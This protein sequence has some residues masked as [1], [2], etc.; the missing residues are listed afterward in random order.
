[1]QRSSPRHHWRALGGIGLPIAPQKDHLMAKLL[2][3]I[4]VLAGMGA[5]TLASAALAAD[6]P[7]RVA[8]P[9]YSPPPL[10]AFTWTGFYIGV[11]AGGIFPDK[12]D[13]AFTGDPLVVGPAIAAG[14]IPGRAGLKDDG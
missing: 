3:S 2:L 13:L 12:G 4:A 6:L 11:N 1:G 9:V 14:I 8:P 5:G 7:R 10:P